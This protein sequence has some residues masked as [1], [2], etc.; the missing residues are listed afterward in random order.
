MNICIILFHNNINGK[1]GQGICTT[2]FIY[3]KFLRFLRLCFHIFWWQ[4]IITSVTSS[5]PMFSVSINTFW[6]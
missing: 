6:P 3:Q 5:L 4:T 2:K 1:G